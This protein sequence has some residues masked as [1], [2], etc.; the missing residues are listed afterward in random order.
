MSKMA[1]FASLAALVAIGINSPVLA[2]SRDGRRRRLI[3]MPAALAACNMGEDAKNI[4]E[5]EFGRLKFYGFP[6]GFL[7]VFDQHT[8]PDD[9][10]WP[11]ALWPKTL[12]SR[13]L[14]AEVET[15]PIR[16]SNRSAGRTMPR[17]GEMGFA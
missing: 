11:F 17:L 3:G 13:T 5:I 9:D 4:T 14:S 15:K 16:I 7:T 10:G 2:R 8:L 12:P 6:G 1:R